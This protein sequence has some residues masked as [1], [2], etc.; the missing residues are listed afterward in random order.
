[1]RKLF[2]LALTAF[3]ALAGWSLLIAEQ[4]Q[5]PTWRD[6]DAAPDRGGAAPERRCA[7]VTASGERCRRSPEPGSDYCWQHGG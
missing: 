1:M 4:K 2:L 6:R 7:A 5:Q 3:A